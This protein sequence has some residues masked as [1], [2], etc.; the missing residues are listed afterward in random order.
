MEKLLFGTA[1]IPISAKGSGTEGGIEEVRN[2]GL[3]AMELEFV[4]GVYLNEEKAHLVAEAAIDSGV[5]LSAHAPYFMNFNSHEPRKLRASQGILC[6]AARIAS[7]CGAESVVFHS[8]FYLG[9]P[10][11]K[12]YDTIKK[13]LAEVVEQLEK[14][15][16]RLYLRPELSGKPSQFGNIEEILGLS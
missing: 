14:E 7:I 1:G 8:G 16:N 4:R 5:K 9:D 6:K 11:Q 3:G 13:Y 10:P 2:L 15:N 12:A